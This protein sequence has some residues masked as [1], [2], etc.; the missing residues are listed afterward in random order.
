MELDPT[1]LLLSIERLQEDLMKHS[2]DCDE[3]QKNPDQEIKG[4]KVTEDSTKRRARIRVKRKRPRRSGS[5]IA[6]SVATDTSVASE[7]IQRIAGESPSFRQKRIAMEG[8][9]RI[10]LEG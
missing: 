2:T 7:N 5:V 8:L 6:G 10:H 3:M 1:D 4:Q 9:L